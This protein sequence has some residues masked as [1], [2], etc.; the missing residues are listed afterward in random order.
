LKVHLIA[1]HLAI[2]RDS[3]V[4]SVG[5]KFRRRIKTFFWNII[6]T[7]TPRNFSLALHN[8]LV[9]EK[10]RR[11]FDREEKRRGN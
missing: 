7:T 5:E 3:N 9:T 8:H 6:A 11:E 1:L 2:A 4:G 10:K